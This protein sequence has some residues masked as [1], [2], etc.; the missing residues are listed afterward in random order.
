MS[1]P[2]ASAGWFTPARYR[3]VLL[4][5]VRPPTWVIGSL[6]GT[7]ATGCPVHAAAASS[8]SATEDTMVPGSV[9]SGAVHGVQPSAGATNLSTSPLS[10]PLV[11][12]VARPPSRLRLSAVFGAVWPLGRTRY[13][14]M[15]LSL[16]SWSTTAK[17]RTVGQGL[18][19]RPVCAAG[20]VSFF[21]VMAAFAAWK[22]AAALQ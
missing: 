10:L 21:A 12:S 19:S 20:T 17:S 18:P 15:T 4:T 3:L 16:W 1:D 9:R 11:S 5:L 7:S 22:K 8:F 2:A 13:E 14:L 6:V